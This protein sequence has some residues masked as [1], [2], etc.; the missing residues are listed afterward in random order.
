MKVIVRYIPKGEYCNG[1]KDCLTEADK[2]AGKKGCPFY[3][4]DDGSRDDVAP[5]DFC[6]LF[7][8]EVNCYGYGKYPDCL[9]LFPNGANVFVNK[10]ENLERIPVK[11]VRIDDLMVRYEF[12]ADM[13]IKGGDEIVI[14]QEIV[15]GGLSKIA[16]FR[17]VKKE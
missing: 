6:S 16:F 14:K 3:F 10:I 13:I 8:K 1:E 2:K 12:P 4:E 15:N 9:E 5:F 7:D 17:K 11:E